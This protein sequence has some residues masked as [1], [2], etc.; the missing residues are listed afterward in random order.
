M[1][2]SNV[3][4]TPH[5]HENAIGGIGADNHTAEN[6]DHHSHQHHQ[7]EFGDDSGVSRGGHGGGDGTSAGSAVNGGPVV[8]N[9]DENEDIFPAP[10]RGG[11]IYSVDPSTLRHRRV[12]LRHS[13]PVV[14]KQTTQSSYSSTTRSDSGFATGAAQPT[15]AS[16]YSSP[17]ERPS[18]STP[19]YQMQH[20]NFLLP[21][22]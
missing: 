11:H 19:T 7:F 18:D 1:A 17:S 13:L 3:F 15:S 20:F 14:S 8:E 10:I 16:S 12:N 4:A 2:D 22:G 5:H 6:S 21:R 9:E